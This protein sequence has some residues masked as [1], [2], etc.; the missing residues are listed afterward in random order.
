MRPSDRGAPIRRQQHDG[1][2]ALAPTARPIGDAAA[3][4][5]LRART[6]ERS[7]QELIAW[8]L[9]DLH[10]P[11]AEVGTALQDMAERGAGTGAAEPA[12]QLRRLSAGVERLGWVLADLRELLTPH[13][14]TL[15]PSQI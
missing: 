14:P 13:D 2:R 11:L 15:L 6:A 9:R 5:L 1:Q 3:S 8:I 10:G 4:A 12:A 7:R